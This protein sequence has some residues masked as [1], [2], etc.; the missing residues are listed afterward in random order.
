MNNTFLKY[1]I[2]TLLSLNCTF[3]QQE[4]LRW[5]DLVDKKGVKYATG[6]KKPFTGRVFDN[7]NNKGRKLTG[8]FKNGKMNGSWT[9]WNEDGNID[10]EE[11]Y[12][13]GEKNGKWTHYDDNGKKLKSERYRKG[14]RL[15]PLVFIILMVK[16]VK[17]KPM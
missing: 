11:A 13:L 3:S 5:D 1:S 4:R 14:K 8:S 12:L 17:M 6:S 10:R 2:I 15:D 16:R 7:Y 9:F